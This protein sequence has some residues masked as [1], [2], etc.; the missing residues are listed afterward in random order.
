MSEIKLC[1]FDMDGLLI[2]SEKYMWSVNEKRAIEELGYE[3]DDLFLRT[4]MG[5]NRVSFR[6]NMIKKY[7]KDFPIDE[8]LYRT[9]KY[10]DEM[11]NNGQLI[12]LKGAIELLEFLNSNNITCR[13]ATST[14]K[15]VALRML[16]NTNLI[17]YFESIIAGD[18]I[19]NSKPDPEIFIKALGDYEK[20]EALIFEDSHNGVKAGTNANIKVV[21]VPNVAILSEEDKRS[22]YKVL[23]SLDETIEVIRR[24]NNIK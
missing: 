6:E 18:T 4:V 20:E 8:F 2:D 22:A 15:E 10:N 9:S 1:I 7:G 14:S 3:S 16:N 17:N 21:L 24:I 5:I 19:K 23:N 11:I 13:V 12:V